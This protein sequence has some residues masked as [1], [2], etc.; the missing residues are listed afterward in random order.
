[1]A[2]ILIAD[3]HALVRAGLHKILEE[4]LPPTS[5][6]EEVANGDELMHALTEHPY[7]VVVLDISMPGQSGLH[8]V[9]ILL[10]RVPNVRILML[11]VHENL[12]YTVESLRVGAH[13]YLRKDSSPA[14]LRAA[15][16]SVHR[17]EAGFPT[18]VAAQL[19]KAARSGDPIDAPPAAVPRAADVLTA[20]EL[21]VLISISLV[22]KIVV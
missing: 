17:G 2:R 18:Q 9:P 12:E 21:E 15:V 19:A 1:M 7:D 5:G 14:E 11:S 13:G 10:E 20:R 8:A 4:G 16:R 6:I 3:D 22:I